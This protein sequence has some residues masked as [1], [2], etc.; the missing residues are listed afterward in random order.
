LQQATQIGGG[1]GR[2]TG[3]PKVVH[4]AELLLE[5]KK[6]LEPMPVF[7]NAVGG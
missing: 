6:I 3:G 7:P 4:V 5:G 1:L 2:K